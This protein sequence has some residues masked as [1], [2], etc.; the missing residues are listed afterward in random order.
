MK[1]AILLF[2]AVACLAEQGESLKCNPGERFK[3][4]CNWC[5]CSGDGV[6]AAT[7]FGAGRH[8]QLSAT[9]G[10]Q[11]SELY[12]D[13]QAPKHVLLEQE[14]GDDGNC[15]KED[16]NR[17]VCSED[18]TRASCTKRACPPKEH[19]VRHTRALPGKAITSLIIRWRSTKVT[20]YRIYAKRIHIIA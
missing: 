16:C 12:F 11:Y 2:L 18:G 10:N 6:S 20:A 19:G 1:F 15:F 17:C 13:V 14:A 4:D 8:L 9:G 7:C 3:L 5:T